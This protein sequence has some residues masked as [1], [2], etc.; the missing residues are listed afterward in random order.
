MATGSLTVLS[1]SR[2]SINGG[3]GLSPGPPAAAAE[4]AVGVGLGGAAV[5][6]AEGATAP[7]PHRLSYQVDD[8]ARLGEL[9]WDSRPPRVAVVVESQMTIHADFAS[10]SRSS[11][12]TSPAARSTR[13]T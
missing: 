1:G 8:P 3:A 12:T 11:A 5:A 2:A 13:S 6:T 10:G 7:A 4:P 9:T